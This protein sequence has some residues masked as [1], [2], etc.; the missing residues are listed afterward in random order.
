MVHATV[1]LRPRYTVVSQTTQEIWD[2]EVPFP[3]YNLDNW[4]PRNVPYEF[5]KAATW[6]V[7][8]GIEGYYARSL[9]E[10]EVE[11]GRYYP[12]EF[13]FEQCCWVE[14]RTRESDILGRYW[15]AYRTV[16]TDLGLDITEAEV[17]LH[18][19]LLT[20][21]KNQTTSTPSTRTASPASLATNPE[22]IAVRESPRTP[23]TGDQQIAELAESLRIADHTQM[24]QT[25]P[26]LSQVGVINPETGHM[27]TED[28]IA[29]YRANLSDRPDPPSGGQQVRRF[30][31]DQNTLYRGV[32]PAPDASLPG[33]GPPA[34]GFPGG[35]FPRWGPPGGGPPG[36]G[37]PGG[38]PPGGGPPRG[39]PPPPLPVQMQ[40][41]D[42]LVGNP[43][44]V[45]TGDRTKSEEFIMQWEMYEG[46]NISN[47]LMHIAYQR[48]LLFMTYI[49]GPLVNEWVK[50]MNAWLHL[51]I[52]RNGR[53]TNDEWL[54]DST[55]LSFNRQYADVLGQE[56]AR[57]ELER[58]FKMEKG[59]INTYIAKF[60]QVI[61]QAG[62]DV[63]QPLVVNKFA[64]GL[65]CKMYDFI[66]THKDPQTYEQW[67][68]EAFK[69]QKRYVHLK[70]RINDFKTTGPRIPQQWW[71]VTPA[72]R[73]SNAMD[74]SPVLRFAKRCPTWTMIMWM[75]P[76][77]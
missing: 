45:F 1:T 4:G 40:G 50:S 28:D 63:D 48:S 51:Q 71:G 77:G 55:L 9:I 22:V 19:A 24:S 44:H 57:A 12:V 54:W 56:K 34:G 25:M 39:G 13:N 27:T 69:A 52:T 17:E 76:F 15:Q 73:D 59:D 68:N 32:P 14:V 43:P 8:D 23:T 72:H 66:Y 7:I 20:P 11:V 36:W 58:G 29:L 47:N 16:A 37:P 2:Q 38:G 35:A 64:R 41:T 3:T 53:P 5:T 10:P 74:T 65:P 60:E 33:R 75:Q 70:N 21:H 31:S 42:K 67:C 30:L 26:V 46:V 6:M 61:R 62:L 18:H 49:Q